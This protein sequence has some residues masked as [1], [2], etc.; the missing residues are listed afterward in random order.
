LTTLAANSPPIGMSMTRRAA[1][2][3]AARGLLQEAQLELALK[4]NE[5]V[6]AG[7]SLDAM[8]SGTGVSVGYRVDA[9]WPNSACHLAAMVA[10]GSSCPRR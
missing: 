2:P 6:R 1:A 8:S 5:R 3:R 10:R 9:V 7:T 4:N